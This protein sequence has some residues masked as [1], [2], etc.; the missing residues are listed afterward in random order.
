MNGSGYRLASSFGK[1]VQQGTA[2]QAFARAY[3]RHGKFGHNP[4]MTGQIARVAGGLSAA[5]PAWAA[6]LVWNASKKAAVA[7][8]RH[9]YPPTTPPVPKKTSSTT[10]TT[11]APLSATPPGYTPPATQPVAQPTAQPTT[12][13]PAPAGTPAPAGAGAGARTGGPNPMAI[14]TF[15]P[16]AG[17]IDFYAQA[18]K[19]SPGSE[20]GSIWNLEAALPLLRDSI[21]SITNGYSKL[22]ANT[23]N[24]LTGGLH[25]HMR[26]ALTEVF[27]GLLSASK[28]AGELEKAFNVSYAEAI[29][30]RNIKGGHTVNV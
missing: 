13:G 6:R 17:A 12:T 30:R 18:C 21:Y 3:R 25:P 20:S 28:A 19:W 15:P 11:T 9:Y 23:E 5:V 24:D 16:Y 26:S 1:G 14:S 4:T 29:A 2:R 7:A 27:V 22:V 10:A 8:Y